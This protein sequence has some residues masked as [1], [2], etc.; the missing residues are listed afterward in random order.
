MRAY[1]ISQ[2]EQDELDEGLD[3]VS[4]FP[5]RNGQEK[6]ELIIHAIGTVHKI[7]GSLHGEDLHGRIRIY[8]GRGG[9][10]NVLARLVASNRTRGH[11]FGV[12]FALCDTSDIEGAE[13][14]AIKMFKLVEST[15]GLCIK[16]FDNI[17][18]AGMG[19]T[20]NTPQSY[21][22]MTWRVDNYESAV[23]RLTPTEIQNIADEVRENARWQ[24][25]L[26][27]LS[28]QLLTSI[29]KHTRQWSSAV[30]L[31]W[32]KNHRPE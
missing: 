14:L 17:A 4:Y 15:G 27:E 21:L 18:E 3:R 22:Y 20:P 6:K 2:I 30:P 31:I 29:L 19:Y 16:S 5:I 7:A 1:K 28:R 23:G 8:V 12:P 25:T 13:T 10:A 24:G 26:G 32:H 11:Q 9:T